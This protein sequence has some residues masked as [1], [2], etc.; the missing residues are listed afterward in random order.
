VPGCAARVIRQSP[1]AVPPSLADTANEYAAYV[2]DPDLFYVYYFARD[3][4]GLEELTD[5]NCMS[6]TDAL[7]PMCPEPGNPACDRIVF[8]ERD[9]I[10]PGTQ[11]GL[12]SLLKLR[13]VVIGLHRP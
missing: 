3:C 11:R 5:G 1:S 8:S 2:S 12:D 4:A 13:P 7:V 10:R 9:Y 6:I